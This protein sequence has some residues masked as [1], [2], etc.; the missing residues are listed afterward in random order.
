MSNIK[1]YELQDTDSAAIPVGSLLR[2][3]QKGKGTWGL[4]NLFT[5]TH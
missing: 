4:L 5:P 3:H 2:V 1:H